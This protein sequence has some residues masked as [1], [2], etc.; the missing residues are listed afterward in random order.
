VSSPQEAACNVRVRR[1]GAVRKGLLGLGTSS[2]WQIGSLMSD[3]VIT[4]KS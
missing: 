4:F 3:M 1:A 2:S